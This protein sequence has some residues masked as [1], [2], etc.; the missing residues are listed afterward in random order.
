[1]EAQPMETL[2]EGGKKF[3]STLT[4]DSTNSAFDQYCT[5]PVVLDW[6]VEKLS[7]DHVK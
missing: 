7:T 5:Q 1:M 3:T 6:D 2:A 4:V